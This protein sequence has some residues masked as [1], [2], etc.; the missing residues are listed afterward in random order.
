MPI[1][2]SIIQLVAFIPLLGPAFLV[3]AA[4]NGQREIAA[5]AV[6]W[7]GIAITSALGVAASWELTRAFSPA[8]RAMIR[9]A[10]EGYVALQGVVQPLDP[11][12]LLSSPSGIPCVWYHYSQYAR[13]KT[14]VPVI[15]DHSTPF[16]LSDRTG[17]C[18][19]DPAHADVQGGSTVRSG[20]ITERVIRPGDSVYV[21]GQLKRSFEGGKEHLIVSAPMRRAF[22]I[23]TEAISEQENWFRILL[24]L[25]GLILVLSLVMARYFAAK[26][27]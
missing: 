12:K 5:S 3:W 19:V 27:S 22:L 24:Y 21:V 9:E 16:L 20:D 11:G 17:E 18:I 6:V 8:L 15:K 25:D 10:A 13:G 14:G 7:W 1:F 2:N 4:A 23:G 26:P